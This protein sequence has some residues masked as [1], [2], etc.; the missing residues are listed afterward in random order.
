[1]WFCAPWCAIQYMFHYTYIYIQHKRMNRPFKSNDSFN[2]S[3]HLFSVCLP[4]CASSR[5]VYSWIDWNAYSHT[6]PN[7]TLHKY[8][9]SFF[10]TFTYYKSTEISLSLSLLKHT[11]VT[12]LI[13]FRNMKCEVRLGIQ[14]TIFVY[15]FVLVKRYLRVRFSSCAMRFIDFLTNFQ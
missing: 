14:I 4:L 7:K 10:T 11:Y 6:S 12:L 8:F 2:I 3:F 5:S 13:M 15:L 1:M 9:F